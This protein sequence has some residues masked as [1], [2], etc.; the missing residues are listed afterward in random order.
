MTFINW[1]TYTSKKHL[2]NAWASLS[3]FLLVRACRHSY[4][5]RRSV[6]TNLFTLTEHIS[7][8]TDERQ[9]VDVLYFDFR[10]AFDQVNND[11]LLAKLYTIGFCP[12]LLCLLTDSLRDRQQCV[13][14][15]IYD[16]RPASCSSICKMSF[17]CRWP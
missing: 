3:F 15:G 12:N 5:C 6:E 1:Y 2:S 10:K 8:E 4:R 11:I 7:V 14:L 13:R 9:K 16:Q 17:I